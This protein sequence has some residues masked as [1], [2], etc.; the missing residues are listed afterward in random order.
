M[1]NNRAADFLKVFLFSN[2]NRFVN[3]FYLNAP[4]PVVDQ[5]LRFALKLYH[6][7]ARYTIYSG[8]SRINSDWVVVKLE[9]VSKPHL[10]A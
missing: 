3:T 7:V 2:L 10:P 9:V 6:G 5:S 4:N 8:M 1:V